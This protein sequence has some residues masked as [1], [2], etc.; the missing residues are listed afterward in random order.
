MTRLATGAT[1]HDFDVARGVSCLFYYQN[2]LSSIMRLLKTVQRLFVKE[3]ENQ[4]FPQT[5]PN[6]GAEASLRP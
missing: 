6:L 5:P 2:K 4:A 3:Q 1:S